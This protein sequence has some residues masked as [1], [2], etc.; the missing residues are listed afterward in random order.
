MTHP[1]PATATGSLA[2]AAWDAW[3]SRL[4]PFS[5]FVVGPG[6]TQHPDTAA[7]VRQLLREVRRPLVLD[8]DALNV[9]AGHPEWLAEAAGP[10]VI[11]PH[12][13]EL[14]RLLNCATA[15]IQNDREA[16]AQRAAQLTRAVVVLKGAGTVVAIAGRPP[17]INL[18]GNPGMATGGSGDIL[19]GLIGG[20][21]AQGLAP[22]DAA[23]AGVYLHGRAGDNAGWRKSQ[24]GL[25]AGDILDE[26][27]YAYREVGI[28]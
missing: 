7:L 11:T 6:L 23:C 12:P 4:E 13:G 20:L 28:R 8:A 27:A 24:V 25:V 1:G 3:R 2:A 19:A 22:F 14:A 21:L 15:D 16:A 5:A 17:S 18:T 26:L 10:V 9:L